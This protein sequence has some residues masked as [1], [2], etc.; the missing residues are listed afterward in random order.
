MSIIISS[1]EFLPILIRL[2]YFCRELDGTDLDGR[3]ISVMEARQKDRGPPGGG[4]GGFS[5]RGG[6]GSSGYGRGRSDFG[7][8]RDD[9]RPS[10]FEDRGGRG[11]GRYDRG[12]EFSGENVLF[13]ILPF[14]VQ[15]SS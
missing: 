7:G 2:P 5:D 6:Y 12:S 10:R 11:E 1:K 9:G 4:R 15:V 13:C 3:S 8:G 14:P